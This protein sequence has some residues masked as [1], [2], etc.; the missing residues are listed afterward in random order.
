M[1][2][3]I[4]AINH[5][6]AANVPMIVA[7]NKIDKPEAD[8]DRIRND[9]SKH[10]LIPEEW[11]GE[12]MFMP[13]SAKTGDRIDA[14]L[15]SILV[16]AEVLELTSIVDCPARG[17]VIE[18]RLD[19]GRGAVASLL[20]QQGTL[21][22]GDLVLAGFE[23]GRIRALFD[24]NGRPVESAGPLFLSK[25]SV[26]P[27]QPN[28]GDDFMIVADERRARE[29][30]LFRQGKFRDIKLA[31]QSASK[32]ENILQRMGEDKVECTLNIVLKSRRTG[33]GR[34]VEPSIKRFNDSRSLSESHLKRGGWY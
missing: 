14:L 23:Y 34:S 22:K 33:F 24:E 3:T 12:T 4:E 1:P 32:L 17:V 26:C 20:V 11:G 15:D 30:A 8:L 10:G 27:V 9:L 25:S 7:V 13:I 31:R 6:K 16:Q 29:V 19:K 18:S 2:Q 21:R 28:A 5:S